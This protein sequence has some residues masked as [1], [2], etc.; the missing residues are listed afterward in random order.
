M[1]T[2]PS[3]RSRSIVG[4]VSIQLSPSMVV[5]AAT[6]VAVLNV[7]CVRYG[8]W[9]MSA[10]EV[11]AQD[12]NDGT[13]RAG[14][15]IDAALTGCLDT[16]RAIAAHQA[17]DAEAGA[18]ALFRMWLGLEDQLNQT[19]GGG[20]DPGGLAAQSAERPIGI[21]SVRARHVVGHS[22]VAM[23]EWVAGMRGN[24]D[25]TMEDLHCAVGNA[26]FEHFADQPEGHG[27]PVAVHFDVV[28]QPG[29]A[30]LPFSVLERFRR[31]RLQRG[32]LD[33]L[34]QRAPAATDP[35]HGSVV[36]L[37]DDGVEFGKRKELPMAEPRQHPPLHYLHRHLNLGLVAGL[38]NARWH[39]RTTV[40]RRHLLI[41]A[42]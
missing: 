6:N 27:I 20:A 32:T 35:T 2:R 31:Q 26:H 41:S 28:V 38:A 11:V 9:T 42:V 3:S 30:A 17:Q 23:L 39:D 37:A 33:R 14:T 16:L 29:P 24:A 36:Q 13:V 10:I 1:P 12:R 8:L 25:S 22:G 21:P 7:R 5:T 15:D 4:W 40:V 18:E 19:R 34:E